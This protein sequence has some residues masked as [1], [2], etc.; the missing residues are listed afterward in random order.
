MTTEWNRSARVKKSCSSRISDSDTYVYG[1]QKQAYFFWGGVGGGGVNR[2]RAV[3]ELRHTLNVCTAEQVGS[4]AAKLI[5]CYFVV[6]CWVWT[7]TASLWPRCYKRFLYFK[8]FRP[9]AFFFYVS[10]HFFFTKPT[11]ASKKKKQ[12]NVQRK[13]THWLSV[14]DHL[15]DKWHTKLIVLSAVILL[16]KFCLFPIILVIKQ[17]PVTTVQKL[18]FSWYLTFLRGQR[19]FSTLFNQSTL[20]THSSSRDRSINVKL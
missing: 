5:V 2:D 6:A 18:N 14:P 3:F 12:T 15:T 20:Q 1:L 7:Q 10:R 4:E 16:K 19:M 8:Y 13:K 11:R 9:C 17:L